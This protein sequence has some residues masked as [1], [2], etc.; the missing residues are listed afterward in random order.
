[1]VVGVCATA[2]CVPVTGDVV[3]EVWLSDPFAAVLCAALLVA[4]VAV[5][6]IAPAP[7][8][9]AVAV[10][11]AGAKVPVEPSALE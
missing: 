9:L 6:L 4:L 11:V 5:L 10:A 3:A 8:S 2:C 7:A 1:M